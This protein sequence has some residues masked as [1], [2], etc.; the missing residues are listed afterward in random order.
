MKRFEFIFKTTIRFDSPVTDQH[1]LLKCLPGNYPFQHIYD[2]QLVFTPSTQVYEGTD[3][4][5]NRILW[6]SNPAPHDTFSFLISGKALMSA[7][8]S[9]EPSDSLYLYETPFTKPNAGIERLAHDISAGTCQEKVL[10]LSNAIYRKMLYLPSSTDETV[11]ASAAFEQGTGVCQD[12][13]HIMLSA[14]RTMGI[15][16]RYC[17]GLLPGEGKS[18]AWVEYYDAGGWHGI[19]PTH[20][21]Q[22]DYGYIKFSHGRDWTDCRINRGCFASQ[23]GAVSQSSEIYA[24][25]GEIDCKSA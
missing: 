12:Y 24:K 5:G 11:T 8:S 21:R 18:H 4:F 13:T 15:P 22:L 16:A 3:S 14:L 9:K 6:G 1:F 17:A 19:D 10:A 23:T 7:Y 20:N 2:E 25:D